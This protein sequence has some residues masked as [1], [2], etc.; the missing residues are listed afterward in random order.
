MTI[1]EC[2]L[3]TISIIEE[4]KIFDLE[5]IGLYLI[6]LAMIVAIGTYNLDDVDVIWKAYTDLLCSGY[7]A[8][9][10][11]QSQGWIKKSKASKTTRGMHI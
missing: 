5:L 10:F 2:F 6:L 4:P 7:F 8:V 1:A 3:Q 11:A 9:D